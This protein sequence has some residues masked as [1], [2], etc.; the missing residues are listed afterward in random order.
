VDGDRGGQLVQTED[1]RGQ[2]RRDLRIGGRGAERPAVAEGLAVTVGHVDAA[3]RVIDGEGGHPQLAGQSE[4]PILRW[5][6]ERAPTLGNPAVP[7]RVVPHPASDPVAG[8]D[9]GD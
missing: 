1:D 5:A 9:H 7:E 8:F 6:D 2:L 4:H 3:T